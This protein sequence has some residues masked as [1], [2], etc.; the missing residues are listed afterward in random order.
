VNAEPATGKFYSVFSLLFG[1]GFGLQL[2]RGGETA[3]PRF[4]RRLRILL[5]IGAIH[6][7][8]IWAGD[9]LMLY[10]LLGL[11]L[12]WFARE[13][14]RE[15][16]RWT[17]FWPEETMEYL[18]YVPPSYDAGKPITEMRDLEAAAPLLR[19]VRPRVVDDQAAHRLG[20]VRQKALAVGE[21]CAVALRQPEIRFVQQGRGAEGQLR[22][23]APQ[24]M[25]R[26]GMQFVVQRRE[27]L[28]R[29]SAVTTIRR[30]H[31]L[32][33]RRHA[34]GLN[35]QYYRPREWIESLSFGP[36]GIMRR[37]MVLIAAGT[38]GENS[39]RAARS[40]HSPSITKA[41][42]S[43]AGCSCAASPLSCSSTGSMPS[44]FWLESR[45]VTK[46]PNPPAR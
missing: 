13:S 27:Q 45:G 26:Q 37:T 43:H 39:R 21:A 22:S 16:L 17:G 31:Q 15:L 7:V 14:N 40:W 18:L 25:L 36:G 12:P 32:V 28:G 30:Q 24:M 10:A 29:G 41:P 6:A 8:L 38:G 33:D 2:A 44:I 46:P 35:R 3:V 1:I 5:A 4:K 42:R 34:G 11:T 19:P 9:I 20:R 23:P